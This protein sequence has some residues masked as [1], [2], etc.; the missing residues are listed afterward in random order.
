MKKKITTTA[1]GV[2]RQR[3]RRRLMR[4][5]REENRQIRQQNGRNDNREIEKEERKW[6]LNPWQYTK[7][8]F[9]GETRV[10]AEPSNDIEEI[11]TFYTHKYSDPLYNMRYRKPLWMPP[12]A[13]PHY[14]PPKPLLTNEIYADILKRKNTRA[15]PG[16]DQL[17]YGIFRR[18][19]SL[20]KGTV[21][22]P[23]RFII[24]NKY[25]K[26]F[27]HGNVTLA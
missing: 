23:N 13:L 18:C 26:A 10:K 22:L 6:R 16:H 9:T 12:V 15:A 11:N 25:P 7:E 20:T 8:C 1:N 21:T 2:E 14:A 24:A 27:K 17:P 5:V 19:H 3:L 4:L